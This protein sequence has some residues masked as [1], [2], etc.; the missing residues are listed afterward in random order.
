[1]QKKTGAIDEQRYTDLSAITNSAITTFQC[2]RFK[3]NFE[4]V[5]TL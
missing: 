2:R 1:M 3:Y 4:D 5:S